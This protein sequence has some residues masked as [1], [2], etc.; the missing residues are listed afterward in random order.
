MPDTKPV[1]LCDGCGEPIEYIDDA[2]VEWLEGVRDR[3][4]SLGQSWHGLRIVHH[5]RPGIPNDCHG[6]D[7]GQ[8]AGSI[9]LN[10][11]LDSL[12][13]RFEEPGEGD[14]DAWFRRMVEGD[15]HFKP[16]TTMAR[17]LLAAGLP[18]RRS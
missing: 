2:W 5:W 6:Y 18:T 4:A 16:F 12:L 8:P 9:R 3:R 17:L 13:E 11:H 7:R 10:S 15:P 14:G 1:L